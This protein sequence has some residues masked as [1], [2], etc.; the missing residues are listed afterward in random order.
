MKLSTAKESENELVSFAQE[1]L[2]E[3][4]L[5]YHA[6]YQRYV[7]YEIISFVTGVSMLQEEND[8]H[9]YFDP[10]CDKDI[11][12]WKVETAEKIFKMLESIIVRY[13]NNLQRAVLN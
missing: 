1:L 7:T 9:G 13:E 11:V 6:Q 5:A 4:P 3:C 2:S 12:A 8:T 10:F